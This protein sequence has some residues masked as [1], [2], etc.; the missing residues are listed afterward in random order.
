MHAAYHPCG[1]DD[2]GAWPRPLKYFAAATCAH[3][4][5]FVVVRLQHD[6]LKGPDAS[7]TGTHTKINSTRGQQGRLARILAAVA[8]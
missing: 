5:S 2:A 7:I 4:E 3:M 6:W 1:A 8:F